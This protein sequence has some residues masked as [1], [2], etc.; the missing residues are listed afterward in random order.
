MEKHFRCYLYCPFQGSVWD[1]IRP[2]S[3]LF[4]ILEHADLSSSSVIGGTG[5]TELRSPIC[6]SGC[7]G[8]R[9]VTIFSSR[10][11]HVGEDRD[12]GFILFITTLE[13]L[14]HGSCSTSSTSSSQQ[15]A[16]PALIA[17]TSF[18]RASLC[19]SLRYLRSLWFDFFLARVAF[20][21]ARMH[22]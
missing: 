14:P 9:L 15:C 4:P 19:N 11:G 3:F 13:G 5:S 2:G 1:A 20:L 12:W 17:L 22:S 16:L 18:Y 7:C 21:L 10:T 6:R 8:K